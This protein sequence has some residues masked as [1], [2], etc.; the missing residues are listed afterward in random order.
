MCWSKN[1]SLVTFI[2]AMVGIIYLYK[3]NAPNDRWV[4][5]F[6]GVVAL[7]QLAEYFMW[8][9]LACNSVNKFA[10]I[11]ALLVLAAEPLAN[12]IG[13]I[14]FSNTKHKNVLRIM[15]IS[16]GLFILYSYF[17]GIDGKNV[18]WCGTTDCTNAA[19][20][21]GFF[22]NKACNLQWHFLSNFNKEIGIIWIIFLI[23]HFHND[24]ANTRSHYVC[25]GIIMLCYFQISNN[26]A[27]GSIWCWLA[28][29]IIFYKILAK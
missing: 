1:V 11:F 16:Y 6:A 22:N 18:N 4:A 10:S 15:L 23:F 8:S 17:Y 20:T 2:L 7:I 12:M 27:Q 19:T 28:I 3:R 24:T 14:Y 9:D 5:I 26:A 13:G 29:S 21:N 25:V